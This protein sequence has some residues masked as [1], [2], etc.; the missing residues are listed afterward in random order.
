MTV[1]SPR[2]VVCLTAETAEL[3][4][5]L[6]CED[7]VVGVTGYAVRPPEVRRKPRVSAFRTASV[8]RI[9]ARRPDLVLGFSDLQSDIAA[10]LIRAGLNVLVT[11]QRTLDETYAA[12]VMVGSALGKQERAQQLA[13]SLRAELNGLAPNPGATWRPAVFF[14]EWDEPL[15]SGIAWVS[16]IIEL[17]GGRDIF[18]ELRSSPGATDR[19]VER[20]EVARRC[21]DIVLASW[22]GKKARLERIAKRPGWSDVPAV[23]NGHI[24]EVKAPDIL[25]PGLSLVHGA[26]QIATLLHDWQ[27]QHDGSMATG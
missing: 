1:W 3:A 12:M 14:E 6:G 8:E 10:Q 5:A 21:P 9:I 19:I 20:D 24:Y 2:R 23:R 22:C 7:V 15:I 18:Q 13:E 11:N 25:Q 4:F 16:E 17:V 27:R 26:R